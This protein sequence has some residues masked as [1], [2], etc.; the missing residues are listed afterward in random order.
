MVLASLWS[1]DSKNEK[2]NK[3]CPMPTPRAD[4]ILIAFDQHIFAC[5]G[6]YEDP[7]TESRI[8]AET[9]DVYDVKT[10]TWSTETKNP[11]PKYYTGV[12]AVKRRI[13][14]IGGLLS[15]N[16]INR[17]TSAVQCYD[18]DTKQWSFNVEWEYPKEVWE[19]TCAAFYVPRERDD[20][21][22]SFY[23]M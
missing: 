2:W 21:V 10:N 19:C 6:W 3:L 20:F 5:G 4:H 13:Y 22:M 23:G 8:L 7:L 15:T 9:I 12:A 14:F 11:M 18:L 17:A 1:F 16:T